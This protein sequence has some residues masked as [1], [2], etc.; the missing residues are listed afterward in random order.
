MSQERC[1]KILIIS[2]LPIWTL[3]QKSGAPSLYKTLRGYA[4]NGW[5]VYFLTLQR[6]GLGSAER[7]LSKNNIHITK[8][9]IPLYT[10]SE[11]LPWYLK[12]ARK[13][14]AVFVFPLL[15]IFAGAK[16]IRKYE[17]DL[18]YGYEIHG[19]LAGWVLSK[20]FRLPFVSRYQGTILAPYLFPKRSQALLKKFEHVIALKLPADLYII[21]NDGTQGD[22]VLN[23]LNPTAMPRL[24]FWRNGLDMSCFKPFPSST[25]PAL[26]SK[27]GVNNGHTVLLTLSRLERWK[28]VDRVIQSLPQVI[29]QEKDIR[30]IIVGDGEKEEREYLEALTQKLSVEDFVE[31][32]GKIPHKSVVEYLNIADIFVSTYDLS[33]VGNPLLE[34]MSCEKCIVT[35][36]NGTTGELIKNGETGM[37]LEVD[38]ADRLSEVIVTLVKNPDLRRELGQK[39]RKYALTNFWTWE[40]RMATE[41]KEVTRLAANGYR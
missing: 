32:V 19:I 37:L 26:R 25:I 40:E 23:T 28:R 36:N 18:V 16:I 5:I 14:L 33:N 12:L 41:V 30:L 9:R 17:I 34:A 2:R 6:D 35:L 10:I 13:F 29:A 39:A 1:R 15:A 4:D 31:F 27:L 21:T 24:R 8:L 20:I 11:S 7:D 3:K 22:L 38:E